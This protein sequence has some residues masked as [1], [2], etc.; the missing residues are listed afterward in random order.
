MRDQPRIRPAPQGQWGDAET[1]NPNLAGLPGRGWR[2][3]SPSVIQAPQSPHPPSALENRFRTPEAGCR[4]PPP[5]S[6]SAAEGAVRDSAGRRGGQRASA[7]PQSGARGKGPLT[8]LRRFSVTFFQSSSCSWCRKPMA[9][10]ARPLRAASSSAPRRP[11]S[12]RAARQRPRRGG[13]S[14]PDSGAGS[15]PPGLGCAPPLR[16]PA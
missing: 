15:A 9:G 12:R 1:R 8:G 14:A 10:P 16:L 11:R 5:A 3:R 4:L 13:A 2:L 7:G 6:P